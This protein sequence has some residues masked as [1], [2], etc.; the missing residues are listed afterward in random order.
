MNS[1][2]SANVAASICPRIARAASAADIGAFGPPM[3]VRAQP[4]WRMIERM[5]SSCS[6]NAIDRA[7]WAERHWTKGELPGSP[8][9]RETIRELAALVATR[10]LADWVALT[11]AVD[12]CVT[13]VLRLDELPAHPLYR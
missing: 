4:G 13:P 3:S 9:A 1:P 12:C 8:A 2:E 5:W 7:A 10:P 6:S 11:D